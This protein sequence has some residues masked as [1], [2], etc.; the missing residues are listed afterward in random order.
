MDSEASKRPYSFNYRG[1]NNIKN[2][3]EKAMSYNYPDNI[4]DGEIQNMFENLFVE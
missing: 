2:V 3:I 4:S 1:K